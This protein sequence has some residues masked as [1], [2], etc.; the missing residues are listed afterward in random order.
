MTNHKNEKEALPVK[1]SDK[2]IP[3]VR[4][5]RLNRLRFERPKE[6]FNLRWNYANPGAEETELHCDT[7]LPEGT[8]L[9]FTVLQLEG[10][11]KEPLPSS[12]DFDSRPEGQELGNS[13]KATVKDGRAKAIWPFP[14][15]S[16]GNV[17]NPYNPANWYCERDEL[18]FEDEDEPPENLDEI[19][20]QDDLRPFVFIVE[21]EDEWVMSPSPAAGKIDIEFELRGEGKCG[22][23]ADIFTAD[24]NDNVLPAMEG[25]LRKEGLTDGPVLVHIPNVYICDSENK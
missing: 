16:N 8:V 14:A 10:G 19:L 9:T 5:G 15:D 1:K 2:R 23:V 17:I 21:Y 7:I 4:P 11:V 25:R 12:Y 20:G 6:I 22:S 18:N 3:G 24:G 13:V